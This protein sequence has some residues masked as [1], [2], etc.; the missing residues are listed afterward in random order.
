MRR[1]LQSILDKL[2]P[3]PTIERPSPKI[4]IMPIQADEIINAL[5]KIGGYEHCFVAALAPSNSME[6]NLDDGMYIILD[7]L[8]YTNLIVGDIIWYQA[9]GYQAVHRIIRIDNDE[10]GWWALCRGDNNPRD[11]GIKVRSHEIRGVW[12]ATLD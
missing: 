5:K 2:F 11:D 7:I 9:S 1:F 10:S 3:Q 4:R 8:P 6:P 12:R